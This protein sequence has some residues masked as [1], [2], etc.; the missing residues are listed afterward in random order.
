MRMPP[1][2]NTPR[3][4]HLSPSPQDLAVN[5][6]E[7]PAFKVMPPLLELKQRLAAAGPGGGG[8]AFSA[9][10][11]TGSGS[12]LVCVGS[13]DAPAFLAADPSCRWVVLYEFTVEGRACG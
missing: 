3:D 5:D 9:V 11:M 4:I 2:S 12:T 6:L 7:P 13:D 10:F 8:G 1:P